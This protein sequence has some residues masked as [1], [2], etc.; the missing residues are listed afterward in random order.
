MKF[1]NVILNSIIKPIRRLLAYDGVVYYHLYYKY[2]NIKIYLSLCCGPTIVLAIPKTFE[3]GAFSTLMDELRGL[4]FSTLEL[5]DIHRHLLCTIL[6]NDD[7]FF[8]WV[9]L[10]CVYW[11]MQNS[12]NNRISASKGVVD[13][14]TIQV[15]RI[16][17]FK[18][19]SFLL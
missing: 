18:C 5:G 1:F 12:Q 3:I 11:P 4:V 16:V 13:Y 14:L 2:Q 17:R 7:I 9:I 19:S 8:G 10:L 6:F 15:N